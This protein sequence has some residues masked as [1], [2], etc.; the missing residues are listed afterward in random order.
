MNAEAILSKIEEDAKQAAAKACDEARQKAETL[1]AASQEKINSLREETLKK[2]EVESSL[3]EDRMKRMSELDLKKEL[4]SAKQQVLGEAFEA[5]QINL[6]AMPSKQL[7]AFLLKKAAE[8]ASGDETLNV[9]ENHSDWFDAQF[10]G[11]L[12]AALKAKGKQGNIVSSDQKIPGYTGL[13]LA[14]NGTEIYCTLESLV[15]NAR[16]ELEAEIAGIL[17]Q[18]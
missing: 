13:V 3:Q 10:T 15:D 2:V 6:C 1:K 17:F 18:K 7:R 8:A 11:D 4:L 16:A 5:A 9:A 14:K 12:N